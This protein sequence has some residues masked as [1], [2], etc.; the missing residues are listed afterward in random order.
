MVIAC[1]VTFWI[2]WVLEEKAN[3]LAQ[4]KRYP[5][6]CWGLLFGITDPGNLSNDCFFTWFLLT[7]NYGQSPVLSSERDTRW[8]RRDSVGGYILVRGTQVETDPCTARRVKRIT[9][10]KKPRY[11][12]LF[13]LLLPW[14]LRCGAEVAYPKSYV[15]M[16]PLTVYKRLFSIFWFFKHASFLITGVLFAIY[17][18]VDALK[19]KVIPQ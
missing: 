18:F 10:T 8:M 1:P 11:A 14:G 15:C 6:I 7:A 19:I 16:I 5:E 4:R 9:G 2:F 17:I 3:W 13:W 12:M